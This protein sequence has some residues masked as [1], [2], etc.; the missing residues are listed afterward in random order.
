VNA[1]TILRCAGCGREWLDQQERWRGSV[2]AEEEREHEYSGPDMV[3]VFSPGVRRGRVRGGVARPTGAE[4][5]GA[6]YV[7]Q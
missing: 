2:A 5:G 4:R 6:G 7:A 1:T 3:A